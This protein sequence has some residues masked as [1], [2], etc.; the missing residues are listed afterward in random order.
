MG[1]KVRKINYAYC[2]K[3]FVAKRFCVLAKLILTFSLNSATT[4]FA[5]Q[6][7]MERVKEWSYVR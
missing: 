2:H 1:E 5:L 7:S 3:E 6:G 4:F